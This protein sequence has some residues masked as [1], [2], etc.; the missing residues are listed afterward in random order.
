MAV[1]RNTGSHCRSLEPLGL[2]SW[3]MELLFVHATGLGWDEALVF[4][5]ALA[6]LTLLLMTR[7]KA[8]DSATE[9]AKVEEAPAPVATR[10][11]KRRRQ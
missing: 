8:D 1:P 7:L 5:A 6:I 2:E 9:A 10:V 4:L 11:G 3:T